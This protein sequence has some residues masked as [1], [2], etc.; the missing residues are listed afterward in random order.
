MKTKMKTASALI[1]AAAIFS[2]GSCARVLQE[3]A[4]MVG[5][6]PTGPSSAS[7]MSGSGSTTVTVADEEELIEALEV[8]DH[9]TGEYI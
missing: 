2:G 8:D 1:L 3:D 9:V 5:V 7:S 6:D 4:P